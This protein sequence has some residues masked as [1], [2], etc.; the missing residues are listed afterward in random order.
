[1]RDE[2]DDCA[3]LA[4]TRNSPNTTMAAVKGEQ[5]SASHTKAITS[6][7]EGNHASNATMSQI[8]TE[9]LSR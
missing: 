5:R 4:V 6:A 7:N 8:T 2:R 3:T 9:G 1:M